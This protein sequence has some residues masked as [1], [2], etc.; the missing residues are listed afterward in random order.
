[1]VLS[2]P[3]FKI[4]FCVADYMSVRTNKPLILFK[5]MEIL[6]YL[7]PNNFRI[8]IMGSKMAKFALS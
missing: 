7:T 8:K 4:D 5:E 3:L 1:M 6:L 2:V